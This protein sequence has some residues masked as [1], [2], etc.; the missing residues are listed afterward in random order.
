MPTSTASTTSA[1]SSLPLTFGIELEHILAFHSS[2]LTPLLPADTKIIKHIPPEARRRL[3]QTTYIYQL[4]RPQYNGWGLA[5][6]TKY[7]SPFGSDWHHQCIKD[8]GY[9]G[10][11]DEILRMEQGLFKIQYQDVVVHD[12]H[13]KMQDYGRWY[14]TTDPSL[15]GASPGELA[16]IIGEAKAN[17]GEWDSGPVELVSRVLNV[18]DP[19]SFMEVAEMFQIL[20]AGHS[21]DTKYKAFTDQWCG[22]HVHI[23]LPP[24]IAISN[25]SSQEDT[26]FTLPVIQHLAYIT[27]VY[28]SVVSLLHPPYRRPG[29]PNAKID[30][31]S[32]RQGFYA[33]PDY[34][35]IDWEA[36]P[37]CGSGCASDESGDD[38]GV[39]LKFPTDPRYRK[40]KG[41]G[42][43]GTET[44]RQ[45]SEDHGRQRVDDAGELYEASD[46][47]SHQSTFSSIS[48]TSNNDPNS[49]LALRHRAQ[50]L[51]F[52]KS[53][54]MTLSKLCYL[55]NDSASDR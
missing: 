51:I 44:S 17:T 47:Q 9:R 34:S 3:R 16:A 4:S 49:P 46:A 30:L 19:N 48:D 27:I 15:E 39:A 41:R 38:G 26:I 12:G 20:D 18:D 50:H 28:E 52:P 53:H 5:A 24:S 31:L 10:Y 6:P 45:L 23:G 21:G 55:M 25:K 32:N 14:L 22:L 33:E 36:Y 40:D 54:P 43:I 37:D 29:H 11:A 7:P 2:L 13:G 42:K 1:S 8:H 35:A